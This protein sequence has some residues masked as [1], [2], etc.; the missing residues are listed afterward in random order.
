MWAARP[1]GRVFGD[2]V[3]QLP[4]SGYASFLI[5]LPNVGVAQVDFRFLS[6]KKNI[7]YLAVGLCVCGQRWVQEPPKPL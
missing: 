3:S 7:S 4:P 2:T 5:C 6:E 1:R